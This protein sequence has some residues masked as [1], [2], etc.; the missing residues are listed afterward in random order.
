MPDPMTREQWLIAA[1][2][3]L[4]PIL[5]E[6]GAMSPSVAVSIGF[7]KRRRGG[8]AH[9]GECW[10]GSLTADGRPAIFVSPI[11]QDPLR[12]LD[13]L[14]HE[15]VH[16]AVGVKCGHRGRFVTVA[17]ACGLEGKPT[18]TI[19]GS[20]LRSRLN[21]LSVELGPL[22]HAALM[23]PSIPSVGSRL[24]LYECFC[25][26]KVR[27]ALDHFDATCNVCRYEFRR[28]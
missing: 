26:V 15:L 19:A 23:V 5:D 25:P 2:R 13:V 21:A 8:M 24:R 3:H 6:A 10:D 20:N 1:C 4:S 22:P 9:L 18:A 16:A 14:L 28:P 12:I 11:L 7:P 17:R 27:V